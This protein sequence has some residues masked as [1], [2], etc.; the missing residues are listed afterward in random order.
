V[1]LALL[2]NSTRAER[3]P[4]AL[5]V[6]CRLPHR[7]T[8]IEATTVNVS[9]T[10]VLIRP[11]VRVDAPSGQVEFVMALPP[12]RAVPL[13]RIRCS[14]RVVRVGAENG[15]ALWALTIERYRFLTSGTKYAVGSEASL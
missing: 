10:G 12:C 1:A 3:F 9:R 2:A 7:R 8:W 4:I 13:A 6:Q 15:W 11:S 5:A 14:G